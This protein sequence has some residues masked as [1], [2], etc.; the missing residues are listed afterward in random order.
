MRVEEYTST[1]VVF[2]GVLPG[3]RMLER[4]MCVPQRPVVGEQ[5][6]RKHRLSTTSSEYISHSTGERTLEA[7]RDLWTIDASNVGIKTV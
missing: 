3:A 6:H 4:Y 7:K 1:K 2:R 5:F